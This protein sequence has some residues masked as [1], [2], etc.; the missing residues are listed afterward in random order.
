MTY[1]EIRKNW[2]HNFYWDSV[3]VDAYAM[4][5]SPLVTKICLKL[6]LIPNVITLLMIA[7]GILGGLL[8][9]LPYTAAKIAGIVFIH[10][11]YVFDCSDGE[12][13][14]IT[15]RYSKFGTEID[16]TAHVIDHPFI[17]FGFGASL[18]SCNFGSVSPLKVL[19]SFA[20][21]AVI[22]LMF[23]S[24]ATFGLIY[25]LKLPKTEDNSDNSVKKVGIK[26]KITFFINIF[27]HVP[28]LALIFPIVFMFSPRIAF[29]YLLICLAMMVLYVP[30]V[31]FAWL[32]RIVRI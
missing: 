16:Y 15:K 22:D 29:I 14:R 26:T 7:S 8:F 24:F 12:V 4:L 17:L 6:K 2:Q 25:D 20:A 18:L 30:L 21:V 32:K 3:L 5:I 27:V 31:G 23:R 11:W 28:N 13:A 10:L 19:L 1:K 9:A